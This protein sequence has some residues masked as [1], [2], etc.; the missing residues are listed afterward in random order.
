[1][2]QQLRITF[3]SKFIQQFGAIFQLQKF[4]WIKNKSIWVKQWS[5]S[6]TF[7]SRLTMKVWEN[8][9]RLYWGHDNKRWLKEVLSFSEDGPIF[10]NVAQDDHWYAQQQ[11]WATPLDS[12]CKY[13][14]KFGLI[15]INHH[16][17]V[18]ST[19]ERRFKRVQL[20]HAR[21]ELLQA[22]GMM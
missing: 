22:V 11:F 17:G 12:R 3:D 21:T 8:M 19:L 14:F 7:L 4:S 16:C 20:L 10:F 15:L 9:V 2:P 5:E 13:N 1:M 18:A 6:T